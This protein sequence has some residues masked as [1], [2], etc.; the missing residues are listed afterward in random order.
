MTKQRFSMDIAVIGGGAFGT[1]LASLLAEQNRKVEMWVRRDDQAREITDKHTNAR[2]LP[3]IN[4]PK[5]LKATTDLGKLVKKSRAILVVVPS[6]AF[7]ETA[8]KIG[9]FIEGD[10]ILIHATKGF[11]LETFKRMSEILREETCARKI[12]VLSGPNLSREILARY[13]AGTLLA[14][15]HEEVV[16]Y[17]Q[18]LFTGGR[19]RVYGGQDIVGTE[20][21]GAFK[22]IIA[23]GAGVSDGMNFG[24]NSKAL[25]VTRGLSEM[26]RLG[27]SLGAD[28]L[29]FG[30]LAGIGDLMATCASPLSRNHQVGVRL[31][32]GESL[33]DI[34]GSMKSVSEG[35]PTTKA[36]YEYIQKKKLDSPIVKAVYSVLYDGATPAN[37]LGEM[38]ARPFH[39]ELAALNI[40]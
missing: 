20:V 27:V 2:Y 26:T 12:G 17:I 18:S 10:Q 4:L 19:F 21:G 23:L 14:S 40:R 1:A 37:A 11:E 29:T 39:D 38:M 16:T 25:L 30:G 3:D 6:K 32:Q 35:V 5:N 34:L 22:N 13:P 9:D 28:I 36:V 7:R 33:D 31:G 15:R 8:R 24:D